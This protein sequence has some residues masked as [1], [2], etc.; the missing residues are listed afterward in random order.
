MN[1]FEIIKLMLGLGFNILI[2]K[3]IKRLLKIPR[4]LMLNSSTYGM[5]STRAASLFFITLYLILT[6]NVT[7][8]TIII[9]FSITILLCAIKYFMK[10]H[11]LLQLLAGSLLGLITAY[12]FYRI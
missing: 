10:E 1:D 2:V 11:S 12:T 3:V 5:P 7:R 4:P 8:N 9:M 6:N